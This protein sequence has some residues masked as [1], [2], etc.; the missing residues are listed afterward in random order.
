M[1]FELKDLNFDGY[2]YDFKRRFIEIDY[3]DNKRTDG[4]NLRKGLYIY[5]FKH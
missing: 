2:L 5:I 1:A 3:S 4:V